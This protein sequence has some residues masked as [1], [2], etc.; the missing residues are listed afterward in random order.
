MSLPEISIYTVY[1]WRQ[2]EDCYKLALHLV[3]GF[4]SADAERR[5]KASA[6]EHLGTAG[7]TFITTDENARMHYEPAVRLY[8]NGGKDEDISEEHFLGWIRSMTKDIVV[9]GEHFTPNVRPLRYN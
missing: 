8:A 6:K 9:D 2:T 5:I 7:M 3:A 1:V 4:D